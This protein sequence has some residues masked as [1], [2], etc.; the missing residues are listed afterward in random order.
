MI[1]AN[2]QSLAYFYARENDNDAGTAGVLTMDEARRLASNFAKLPMLLG[3]GRLSS[4]QEARPHGQHSR[5]SLS[6]DIACLPVSAATV[7]GGDGGRHAACRSRRR[8]GHLLDRSPQAGDIAPPPSPPGAP[9]KLLPARALC[10]EG[11]PG[12]SWPSLN[13]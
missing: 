4:K 2:G 13:G 7:L 6:W 10:P 3:K 11:P 12:Q 1:D 9:C 5:A 8:P